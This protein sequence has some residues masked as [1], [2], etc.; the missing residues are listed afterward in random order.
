MGTM[1]ALQALGPEYESQKS[2]KNPGM[3]V[4]AYDPTEET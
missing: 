2:H 4:H 1:L 3:V